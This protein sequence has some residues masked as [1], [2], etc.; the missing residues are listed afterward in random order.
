MPDD[1]VPTLGARILVP[2]AE[3]ME[4]VPTIWCR[5]G[6]HTAPAGTGDLSALVRAF[7]AVDPC[8]VVAIREVYHPARL[9]ER[10]LSAAQ[11]GGVAGFLEANPPEEC[12]CDPDLSIDD[13]Y[14]MASGVLVIRLEH[15]PWC[16]RAGKPSH[17][18]GGLPPARA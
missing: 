8:R 5:H 6:P 1:L 7:E 9:I 4:V 16:E 17:G 18:T 10:I 11:L 3:G 13:R 12:S 2:R 14:P 15:E